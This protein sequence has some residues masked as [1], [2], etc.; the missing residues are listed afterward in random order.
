MILFNVN[1]FS[2]NNWGSRLTFEQVEMLLILFVIYHGVSKYYCIEHS[3]NYQMTYTK[4]D[5][6]ARCNQ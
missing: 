5:S 4:F 6:I 1:I 3:N 2:I